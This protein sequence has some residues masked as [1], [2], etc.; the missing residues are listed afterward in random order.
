MQDL[1]SLNLDPGKLIQRTIG[2]PEDYFYLYNIL[3]NILSLE[4]HDIES[5][6]S[7]FPKLE[8]LSLV[9]LTNLA[10]Y[11]VAEAWELTAQKQHPATYNMDTYSEID[12]TDKRYIL[13]LS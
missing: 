8:P 3:S 6:H 10:K 1:P 2:I 13:T 9:L 5:L 12:A 4:A 11:E 7:Y